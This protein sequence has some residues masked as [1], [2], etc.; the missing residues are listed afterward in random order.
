MINTAEYEIAKLLD[1]I[2]KPYIPNR[3]ML[4]STSDFI[5]RLKDFPF[6]NS[7]KLVSYDVESLFT[8]VPL[9]ETISI[10]CEYV[11]KDSTGPKIPKSTFKQL[12][13]IATGGIFTFEGKLYRQVDGITMGSPL[14]PTFA[15]FFLAHL[16]NRFMNSNLDFA[17]DLYLR[18]VDDIFCVFN[19]DEAITKFHDFLN[20]LHPNLRFTYELGPNSIAFLDTEIHLPIDETSSMSST[21]YRKKTNTNVVMNFNALCPKNWNLGL[22]YC[23]LNRAYVICSTWQLFHTEVQNLKDIFSKNGYPFS[24]VYLIIV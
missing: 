11:Y 15:N 5:N 19:S 17:P 20:K 12:L 13:Q 8:N 4:N 24:S 21:V 10:I 6:R 14:G 9:Q 16:E 3:F 23:L 1:N 18:Y 2:I 22:I 7:Q